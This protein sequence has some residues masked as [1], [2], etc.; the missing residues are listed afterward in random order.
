ML[1]MHQE[2]K[3]HVYEQDKGSK[4]TSFLIKFIV[5]ATLRHAFCMQLRFQSNYFGLSQPM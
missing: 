2:V 4:C 3:S 5:K 1:L